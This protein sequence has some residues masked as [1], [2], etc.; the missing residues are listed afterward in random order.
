[1]IELCAGLGNI[2]SQM[3]NITFKYR[4][5]HSQDFFTQ[6]YSYLTENENACHLDHR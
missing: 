4:S 1:M 5:F 6:F 2:S 3:Q